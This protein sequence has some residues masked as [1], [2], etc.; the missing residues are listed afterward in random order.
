MIKNNL[1][2]SQV[3]VYL[4]MLSH[5]DNNNRST[6]TTIIPVTY[7]LKT[8]TYDNVNNGQVSYSDIVFITIFKKNCHVNRNEKSK[9]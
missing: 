3:V 4:I 6:Q 7:Y 8:N 9:Y 2:L 5:Y 1:D